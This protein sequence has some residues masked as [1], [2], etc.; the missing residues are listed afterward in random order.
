[1]KEW[2]HDTPIGQF[3]AA[4][5]LTEEQQAVLDEHLGVRHLQAGEYLWREG[6]VSDACMAFLVK[7]QIKALKNNEFARSQIVMGLLAPGAVIGLPFGENGL[8]KRATLQASEDCEL[9]LMCD[10]VFEHIIEDH[11]RLA[12]DLLRHIHRDVAQ[13]MSFITDRIARFF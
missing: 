2:N 12:I 3:W 11:P 13:K 10:G 5:H 9:L 8:P 4:L 1:M 6:E 7:G